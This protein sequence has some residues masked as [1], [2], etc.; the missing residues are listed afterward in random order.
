MKPN[1]AFVLPRVLTRTF[2]QVSLAGY[3]SLGSLGVA[4]LLH[5]YGIALLLNEPL[6]NFTVST[7]PDTA[8]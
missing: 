8:A 6:C 2:G 3:S 7:H 1:A 5:I 4:V